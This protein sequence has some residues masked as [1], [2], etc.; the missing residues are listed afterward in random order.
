MITSN[1][2]MSSIVLYPGCRWFSP[3]AVTPLWHPC[4]SCLESLPFPSSPT[5]SDRPGGAPKSFASSSSVSSEAQDSVGVSHG[6]LSL[7][8]GFGG[9]FSSPS[10]N[11]PCFSLATA[12]TTFLS[13]ASFPGP[14][15]H[16]Q[17]TIKLYCICQ[18]QGKRAS[19]RDKV[20]HSRTFFRPSSD[21]NG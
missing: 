8:I 12:P 7:R 14:S 1:G 11:S 10:D 13:I 3:F 15:R 17:F 16:E 6:F 9:G 19:N 18:R 4:S 20:K 5:G 2:L 21:R